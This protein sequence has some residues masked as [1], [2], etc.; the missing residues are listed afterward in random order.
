[1]A[2]ITDRTAPALVTTLR[3]AGVR[4]MADVSEGTRHGGSARSAAAYRAQVQERHLD[5]LITD[6]PIEA[7]AALAGVA[8]RTDP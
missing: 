2:Y 3:Q 7:R 8:G 1:V 5:I 4:I 6:Y